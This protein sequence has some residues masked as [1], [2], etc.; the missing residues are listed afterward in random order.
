M[1]KFWILFALFIGPLLFYLFLASGINNFYKLSVL[2]KQVEDVNNFKSANGE[3]FSLKNNVTVICFLGKD[4]LK[5]KTNALNL[6]EKIY[7][8]FYQYNDFQMLALLPEG[9]QADVK[10]LKKELGVTTDLVKWHFLYASPTEIESFYESFKTNSE[11]ND[12]A[13]TPL[14]FIIDKSGD[15]RGRDDDEDSQNGILYGY[16]ASIVSPIHKKMVD[17]VKV[18]LAEYR[19]AVK[20]KK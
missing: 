2:T 6:N 20:K 1:K 17:D 16:D 8:H 10:Q 15:L 14:A 3:R 13:Y 12:S 9:T 7:K 11:L 19:R 4:L 18:L 5:H